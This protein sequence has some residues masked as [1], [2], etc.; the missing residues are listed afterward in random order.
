VPRLA[1]GKN[2]LPLN[3][4]PLYHVEHFQREIIIA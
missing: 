3:G 4:L 1:G 2:L